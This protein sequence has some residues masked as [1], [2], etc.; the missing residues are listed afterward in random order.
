V[1]RRAASGRRYESVDR[2]PAR[3]FLGESGD[4]V[5]ERRRG[6][7]AAAYVNDLGRVAR[8]RAGQAPE[9]VKFSQQ[10]LGV[11]EQMPPDRCQLDLVVAADEQLRTQFAFEFF[12]RPAYR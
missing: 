6:E 8:R 1:V 5:D 10:I 9:V 12:H 7:V 3:D 4:A 11:R 2:A